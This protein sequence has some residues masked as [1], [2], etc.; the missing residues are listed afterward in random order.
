MSTTAQFRIRKT[1]GII[2]HYDAYFKGTIFCVEQLRK[3]G[4]IGRMLGMTEDYWQV[5][6]RRD[7]LRYAINYIEKHISDMNAAAQADEIIEYKS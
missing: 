2:S 1:Y 5:V 4:F 3:R 6:A 7:D